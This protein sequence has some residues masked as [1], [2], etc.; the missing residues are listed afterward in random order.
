[1]ENA[2]TNLLADIE[3]THLVQ[4]STGKR[5]FN[6]I[7]DLIVYYIIFI[8]IFSILFILSPSFLDWVNN[9]TGTRGYSPIDQLISLI[10]YG[11]TLGVTETITKGRSLGKLITGTKVVNQ[12]GSTITAKTA[13]LRGLYRAVPFDVLSALSIPSFP[14]HDKWSKTYVI[15]VKK[16]III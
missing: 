1:M 8:V 14:W 4:A 11:F 9:D 6:L 13:F 3:T 12:D 2:P 15:D 10:F 16:S 5:F 7:I